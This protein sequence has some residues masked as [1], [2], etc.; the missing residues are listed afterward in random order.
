MN[1]FS[2]ELGNGESAR[3]RYSDNLSCNQARKTG[4]AVEMII[5]TL[6]HSIPAYHI[7]WIELNTDTAKPNI[8]KIKKI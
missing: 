3:N 8:I 7:F 6:F 5:W 2:N 4:M 1:G